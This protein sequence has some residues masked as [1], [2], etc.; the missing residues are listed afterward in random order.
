MLVMG[1]STERI[2]AALVQGPPAPDSR[3]AADPAPHTA[4][5]IH[6]PL[7]EDLFR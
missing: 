1:E 2:P 6:R 4:A 5:M 7:S 3:P